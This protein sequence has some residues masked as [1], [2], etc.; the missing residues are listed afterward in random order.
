MTGKQVVKTLQKA[1]WVIDRKTRHTI[2]K[3]NSKTVP[4]PI[5]GNKDLPIGTL[6]SIEHITGVKL[7]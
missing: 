3:K 5:H 6:K 2:L 1:G 4:V 7:T